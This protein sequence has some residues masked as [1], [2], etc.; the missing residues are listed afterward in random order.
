MRVRE[1][2]RERE[3]ERE[4]ETER[5]KDE[6]GSS[7]PLYWFSCSEGSCDITLIQITISTRAVLV[8]T[9]STTTFTTILF[10]MADGQITHEANE[11]E[12]DKISQPMVH[13]L[14]IVQF[15][16]GSFDLV[17]A[18]THQMRLLVSLVRLKRK[19]VNLTERH[20]PGHSGVNGPK[21]GLKGKDFRIVL[22]CVHQTGA[23]PADWRQSGCVFDWI[24]PWSSRSQP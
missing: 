2:K 22:S 11:M 10:S 23:R 3:R 6:K 5:G 20:R 1:R 4:S 17:V 24:S 8:R 21:D 18:F 15:N 7:S 9:S 16:R 13:I 12:F 14:A 19:Q